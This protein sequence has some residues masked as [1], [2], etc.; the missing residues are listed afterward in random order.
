MITSALP[1]EGKTATAINLAIVLAQ[2]GRRVL[3]VDTDLRRPRLHK[4]F[5]V[6]NG[7]GASTFLS[8]LEDDPVA[9]RAGDERGEPGAVAERTDP[10]KSL[11]SCSTRRRFSRSWVN[12]YWHRGLRARGL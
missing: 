7:R 10:S 1:E 6:D 2:L 5:D 8:G 11:P 9:A 3:I 12:G 4:A